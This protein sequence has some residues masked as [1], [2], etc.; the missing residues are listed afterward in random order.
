[1]SNRRRT[2]YHNAYRSEFLR[3]PAWHARRDRWFTH[4][5]TQPWP[6]ICLG[7]GRRAVPTQ[8]ELHHLTY[9]RVIQRAPGVWVAAEHHRDLIP[10]HPYC[11]ELLHR[12]MDRDAVLAKN[13]TRAVATTSAL[14]RLRRALID[15]GVQHD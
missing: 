12:L 8:L 15:F 9:E 14:V 10:L 11:H 6:L 4:R 7:C 3:S 13:R 2:G 5:L 1:M